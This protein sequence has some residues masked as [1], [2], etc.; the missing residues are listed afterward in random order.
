MRRKSQ[1]SKFV[2][3]VTLVLASLGGAPMRPDEVEDVMQ[4]MNE[5][6]IVYELPK[7]A[8][9]GDDLVRKLLRA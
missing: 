1:F 7:D 2:F 3:C 8:E 4:A 6:E 9:T 5:P